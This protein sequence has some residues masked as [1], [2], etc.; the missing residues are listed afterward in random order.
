MIERLPHVPR[1]RIFKLLQLDDLA[2]CRRVSRG[3]QQ[4]VDKYLQTI[5]HVDVF[6]I[7][8]WTPQGEEMPHYIHTLTGKH[9]RSVAYS[10]KKISYP[11]RLF[12]FI[13]KYTPQLVSINAPRLA[14]Q[15]TDL[16]RIAPRLVYFSLKELDVGKFEQINAKF[17][18]EKFPRLL[19]FD[20]HE[21]HRPHKVC[22]SEV[23]SMFASNPSS[24]FA[25]CSND[26]SLHGQKCPLPRRFTPSTQALVLR[27]PGL[28]PSASLDFHQI[29]LFVWRTDGDAG[30]A[31]LSMPNLLRLEI[32]C[33][34]VRTNQ[35]A[36]FLSQSPMLESIDLLGHLPGHKQVLTPVIANLPHLEFLT[37]RDPIHEYRDQPLTVLIGEKLNYLSLFPDSS[38]VLIQKVAL[39]NMRHL[40]MTGELSVEFDFSFPQLV[41]FSFEFDISPGQSLAWIIRRLQASPLLTSFTFTRQSKGYFHHDYQP[42]SECVDAFKSLLENSRSLRFIDFTPGEVYH[43]S[44]STERLTINLN[45][46]SFHPRTLMMQV[47]DRPVQIIAPPLI[48][49]QRLTDVVSRIMFHMDVSIFIFRMPEPGSRRAPSYFYFEGNMLH[50]FVPPSEIQPLSAKAE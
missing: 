35:L 47:H 6:K 5:Q 37:I 50:S 28:V 10:I 18:H 30:L 9:L 16:K 36:A 44:S 43:N 48:Q 33:K 49:E 12:S 17:I 8:P 1:D 32:A 40:S 22:Q 23:Y 13:S 41:F 15:W 24:R 42:E 11:S 38:L 45:S 2:A 39:N 19:A 21:N 4:L 7:H 29:K 27:S 14:L 46:L 3:Y 25:Q 20:F 31:N 26:C 34:S